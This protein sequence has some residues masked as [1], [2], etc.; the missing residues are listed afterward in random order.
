VSEDCS[1]REREGKQFASSSGWGPHGKTTVGGRGGRGGGGG[2]VTS[3]I[4]GA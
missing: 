3:N 2:N 4:R 1:R